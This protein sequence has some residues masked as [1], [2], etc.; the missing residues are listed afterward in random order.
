MQAFCERLFRAIVIVSAIH[1]WVFSHRPDQNK[2]HLYNTGGAVLAGA[3]SA[4]CLPGC[5]VTVGIKIAL[6]RAPEWESQCNGDGSRDLGSQMDLPLRSP[7][8]Q[9]EPQLCTVLA[10]CCGSMWPVPAAVSRQHFATLLVLV[11]WQ[12]EEAK[13]LRCMQGGIMRSAADG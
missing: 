12:T 10:L 8:P 1:S 6:R 4:M 7:T 13:R 3:G 11:A 9:A 5:P 2:S